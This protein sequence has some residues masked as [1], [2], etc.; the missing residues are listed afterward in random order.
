MNYKRIEEWVGNRWELE[1]PYTVKL[2]D[3]KIFSSGGRRVRWGEIIGSYR[4][5]EIN[6]EV[7]EMKRGHD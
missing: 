1:T 4:V 2:F 5:Y 7:R 6:F 3:I